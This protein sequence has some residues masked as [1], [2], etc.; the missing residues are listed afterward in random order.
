MGPQ[1]PAFADPGAARWPPVSRRQRLTRSDD[2]LGGDLGEVVRAAVV[3]FENRY[4]MTHFTAP[5]LEFLARPDLNG[6]AL[7]HGLIILALAEVFRA[8]ARLDDEQSLTV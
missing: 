5:G 1:P 3:Y 7:V 2:R 6:F 8:G 4:A